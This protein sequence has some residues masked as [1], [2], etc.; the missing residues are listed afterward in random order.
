MTISATPIFDSLTHPSLDGTW[1]T[2]RWNGTNSFR[3]VVASMKEANVRWAWAVSMG[4]TGPYDIERYVEACAESD[5]RL[6]PAA[7]MDVSAFTSLPQVED[8]L[9]DRKQRGFFGVKLHPRVGHF[10]FQHQ[11]LPGI[12]ST[13]NR[14]GLTP[15]LCTYFHS[16]DPACRSPSLLTLRDMLCQVHDEKLILLHSGATRLLDVSEMTRPFKKVLL[17]LSWTLCEFDGSSLDLDLRYVMDRC[18]GRVCIGSDSPEYLPSQMRVRFDQLTL[19]FSQEH[20]EQLAFRN[21]FTLTGLP[22]ES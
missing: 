14:L 19:G 15:L 9:L 22:R 12:I 5:V 18:R 3:Q 20:R 2:P 21:M 4:T 1:L 7:F 8:W 16:G 6:F 10:D 11:L 17:D 13:A